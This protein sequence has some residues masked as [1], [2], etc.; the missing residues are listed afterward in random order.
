MVAVVLTK[1]YPCPADTANLSP[2]HQRQSQATAA[3][4]WTPGPVPAGGT[5]MWLTT[6]LAV[7][8]RPGGTTRYKAR[9]DSLRRA[10]PPFCLVS[11]T[12]SL[13]P[14]C[15]FVCGRRF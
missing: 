12:P 9:N 10:E 11:L 8:G 6:K 2:L 5:M 7:V 15:R 3:D 4:G 14:R 13:L 1:D